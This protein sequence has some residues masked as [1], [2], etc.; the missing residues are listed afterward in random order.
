MIG[1][2]IAAT[3]RRFSKGVKM[4]D[5]VA[6]EKQKLSPKMKEEMAKMFSASENVEVD[7]DLTPGN[8]LKKLDPRFE[9]FFY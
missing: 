8:F 2:S 9:E 3:S 5:T 7:A 6:Y 1:R 4:V